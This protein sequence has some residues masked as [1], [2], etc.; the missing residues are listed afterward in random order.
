M[1]LPDPYYDHA[2]CYDCGLEYKSPGWIEVMIPDFVWR[3][4][5]PTGDEEGLLCISCISKK[6][7]KHGFEKVPIWLCEPGPIT[8]LPIEA[9][10]SNHALMRIW[11]KKSK[12]LEKEKQNE[13]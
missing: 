5:S 10:R 1:T 11:Y 6:L 3:E 8:F 12:K 7:I 9:T 13:T 2:S 4:I